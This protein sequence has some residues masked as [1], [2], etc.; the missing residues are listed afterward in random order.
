MVTII[1]SVHLTTV[2]L[3]IPPGGFG[4]DLDHS[5]SVEETPKRVNLGFD[6]SQLLHAMMEFDASATTIGA[7]W[8]HVD[9]VYE[10]MKERPES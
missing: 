9:R 8:A 10:T 2:G 4:E 5:T 1:V 7:F 6:G 3:K